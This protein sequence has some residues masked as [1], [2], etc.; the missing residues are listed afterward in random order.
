VDLQLKGKVAVVSGGT[1]GIGRAIAECFADEGMHVAICARNQDDIDATV[2]ALRSKGVNAWGQSVDI[3]DGPA[4]DGFV[5]E[6]ANVLGGIDA[7]VSNASALPRVDDEEAWRS[8]FEI[9]MLG[10]IRLFNAAQTHLEAAA[11]RSGDAAFTV[12]SS[13]VAAE[14]YKPSPYS[15]IK[16]GLINYAKGVARVSAGKKIRC[17]VLSPGNV[18]FKG[19]VWER[20]EQDMPDYFESMIKAN[21]TGRMGTPEEIA[22]AVVFLSSPRS[23]F[24]TGANL[25]VDGSLTQRASF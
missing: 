11:S 4:I 6:A 22:S 19:G 21:P 15:A 5:A 2:A 9:D 20:I 23:S 1:R 16:A 18:Y 24:T 3:S 10:A 17:N 8:M 12:I 7:L 13:I 25:V 14:P